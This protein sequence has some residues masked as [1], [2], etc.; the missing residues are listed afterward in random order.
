MSDRTFGIDPEALGLDDTAYTD[1]TPDSPLDAL[2]A[3][4]AAKVKTPTI[5][6]T[7]PDRP[8]WATEHRLDFTTRDLDAWRKG[9]RDK[10]A[11]GG[12]DMH[13]F[14]GLVVGAT[15][16]AIFK[17]GARIMDEDGDAWT[18]T[19]REVLDLF[20]VKNARDAAAAW[21]VRDGALTSLANG[22]IAAAG[23]GDEAQPADPTA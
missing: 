13:K 15:C 9:S 1:T 11:D 23:Y 18:L 3:E 21:A 5:T 19:H 7:C 4:L 20:G 22:I 10:T 2:R 12:V 14:A 17:D 16:T 8:G 6:L